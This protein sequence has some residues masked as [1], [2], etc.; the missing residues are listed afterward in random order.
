M[1]TYVLRVGLEPTLHNKNLS[2]NQ[3]GLPIPP[4]E[5][6]SLLFF[7]LHCKDINFISYMQILN[8]KNS[9]KKGFPI[10]T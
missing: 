10:P 7:Y 1:K 9:L 8:V 2:L 5:R 4:S 3:A 6:P